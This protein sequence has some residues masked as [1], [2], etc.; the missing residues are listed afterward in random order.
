M[1]AFIIIIIQK[2]SSAQKAL[3]NHHPRGCQLFQRTHRRRQLRYC[4]HLRPAA[5]L[6]SGHY[7]IF[8]AKHLDCTRNTQRRS[9]HTSRNISYLLVLLL[10]LMLDK[11]KLDEPT[12]T[13]LMSSS[14]GGGRGRKFEP[15]MKLA[16]MMIA[17]AVCVFARKLKLSHMK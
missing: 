1:I 11:Q 14:V 16:S 17:R 13:W 5:Q 4:A 15:T 3:D 6:A 7:N 10:L 12:T 9:T 8:I 2:P